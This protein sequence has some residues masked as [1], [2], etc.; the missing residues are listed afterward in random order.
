MTRGQGGGGG[1]GGGEWDTVSFSDFF[2]PRRQRENSLSS[3]RSPTFR[4]GM[5]MVC[6]TRQTRGEGEGGGEEGDVG[7]R[8]W[9]WFGEGGGGAR[10]TVSFSHFFQRRQTEHSL[11]SIRSP[12]SRV[13]MPMVC[14]MR[15]DCPAILSTASASSL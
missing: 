9:W 5:P 4:V 13:G 1:G 7:E 2:F 14:R 12:M 8:L 6:R 15:E 10:G 11:S 3:I